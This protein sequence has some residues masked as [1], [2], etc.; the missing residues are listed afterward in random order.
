MSKINQ[1]VPSLLLIFLELL[2][3]LFYGLF[4][5]YHSDANILLHGTPEEL[6]KEGRFARIYKLYG[7]FQDIHVMMFIGFGFLMTFLKK[8]WFSSLGINFWLAALTLQ[9]YILV[10]G[11]FHCVLTDNWTHKIPIHIDSFITGDFAAASVLICFG[12]LLGKVSFNQMTIIALIQLVFYTLNETLALVWFKITDIGGSMLIHSFGAYFG[13]TVSF[14][15][16]NKKTLTKCAEIQGSNYNSDLFSMIG[17][18]FLWMYWPSF[19]GALA[20]FDARERVVFHTI[21]SLTNSCIFAFIFSRMVSHDK[22]FDMIH[23][24]NASLAG[25]VAIGAVAD[26]PINGY[27]AMIIGAIAGTVSVLGFK[28]LLPYLEKKMGLHDTCGVHNL[29]GLPGVIG[30]ICSAIAAA[31]ADEET[32]GEKLKEFFP[33]VASGGRTAVSQGS[34]QIL[35]LFVSLGLAICG[36]CVAAIVVKLFTEENKEYFQDIVSWEGAEGYIPIMKTNLQ[37]KEEEVNNEKNGTINNMVRH[38][39]PSILFLPGMLGEL[40]NMS[41]TKMRSDTLLNKLPEHKKEMAM[42]ALQEMVNLGTKIMSPT[43]RSE[44]ISDQKLFTIEQDDMDDMLNDEKKMKNTQ[45]K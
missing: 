9:W 16:T 36:G 22:K 31:K 40:K 41:P 30:G 14:F 7:P 35:C 25:G 2:S 45:E 13:L 5:D 28:Y 44:P 8:F 26:L 23:I 4:T 19:N 20:S 15:I 3:I 37:A 1:M 11:F 10:Q 21:I 6:F 24:Q 17:T 34:Y 27:A 12:A 39:K 33:L 18:I 32:Y 29:H 38:H 43:L 42:Q